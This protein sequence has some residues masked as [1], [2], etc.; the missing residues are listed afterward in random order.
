MSYWHHRHYRNHQWSKWY[1]KRIYR[2]YPQRVQVITQ[3][4][5]WY[6]LIGIIVI[7]VVLWLKL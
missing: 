1:N 5:G 2:Y 3:D 7:A 6:I 4:Y